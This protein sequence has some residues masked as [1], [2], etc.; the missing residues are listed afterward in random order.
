MSRY[1]T[2]GSTVNMLASFPGPALYRLQFAHEESLGTRLSTS[3]VQ[4]KRE[5]TNRNLFFQL[6][7]P[8]SI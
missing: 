4:T 1:S 7:M 8:Y 5:I 6:R 3:M 2:G